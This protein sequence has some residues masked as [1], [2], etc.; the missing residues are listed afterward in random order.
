MNKPRLELEARLVCSH[1]QQTA[2]RLF[3]RQCVNFPGTDREQLLESFEHVLWPA[4]PDLAPPTRPWQLCCPE[5]QTP[6]HRAA[7]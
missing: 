1:C 5:C 2:Y 6:L 3:R 7:P 4:H